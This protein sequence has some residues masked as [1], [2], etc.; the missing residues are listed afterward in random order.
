MAD[1]LPKTLRVIVGG[2]A[3]ERVWAKPRRTRSW[4]I[5]AS[6]GDHSMIS[7]AGNEP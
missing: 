5:A 1:M 4:Q 7:C 2:I 3:M 6:G